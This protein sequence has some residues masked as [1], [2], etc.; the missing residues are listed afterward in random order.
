MSFNREVG[1]HTEC[2]CT[3]EYYIAGKSESGDLRV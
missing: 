1:K 3:M 2:L